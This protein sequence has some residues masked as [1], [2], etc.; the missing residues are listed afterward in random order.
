MTPVL[1]YPNFE[2]E[3]IIHTDASGYAIGAILSQE[4]NEG[5]E[6]VI[7][8]AARSLSKT[9]L[10]YIT[11][12]KEC[13]VVVWAINKF[14]HYIHGKK[15]KIIMDHNSLKWLFTQQIKGRIG[16]WIIKLQPYINE[17]EILHRAGKKHQNADALSWIKGWQE[18]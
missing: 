11:M 18:K 17:L 5:K 9:E 12:E 4:D 6:Y 14:H 3:F 10:V 7:Q 16:R 8:Y 15:C 2:K 13:L 1:A